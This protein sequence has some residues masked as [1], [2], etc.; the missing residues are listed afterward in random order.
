MPDDLRLKLDFV[1]HRKTKKM[2]LILGEKSVRCL[3][4]LWGYAAR[5]RQKGILNDM[6]EIDIAIEAGWD[7]DAGEFISGLKDAGYLKPHRK[8]TWKLHDWD[9]HQ[10]W[11][12]HA[13][14]RSEKARKAIT[15]RWANGDNDLDDTKRI[16]PVYE[17]NTNR[18]TPLPLPSPPPNPSPLPLPEKEKPQAANAAKGSPI[19]RFNDWA[20]NNQSEIER[21]A[22][23]AMNRDY[24]T[25]LDRWTRWHI[26][27]MR[28]WLKDP[29]NSKK[30]N[31]RTH[32]HTFVKNWLNKPFNMKNWPAREWERWP[33][34]CIASVE[35][36]R[37]AAKTSDRSSGGMSG[38]SETITKVTG[39][40]DG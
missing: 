39:G 35:R 16:P 24:D 30:A 14:E 32:W 40:S 11:V 1:D 9:V 20:R 22:R 28:E 5:H 12:Y 10:P 38:I 13:P 23:H 26:H 31:A 6:T 7:G 25:P 29:K 33:G 19:D 36:E 17:P 37:E 21:F 18:N 34:D 3:L 15:K 2:V 4:R 8:S 27:L